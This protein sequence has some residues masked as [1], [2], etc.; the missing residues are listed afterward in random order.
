MTSLLF[1][2][3]LSE[4]VKKKNE[5]KLLRM[6]DETQ[7]YYYLN[8]LFSNQLMIVLIL[9][10]CLSSSDPDLWTCLLILACR[11]TR[12]NV[13]FL[14]LRKVVSMIASSASKF[15]SSCAVIEEYREFSL[16]LHWLSVLVGKSLFGIQAVFSSVQ[17]GFNLYIEVFSEWTITFSI[18]SLLSGSE[19]TENLEWLSEREFSKLDWLS[20]ICWGRR[21]SSS[22]LSSK[23]SLRFPRF[24][25]YIA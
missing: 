16:M 4:L 13:P 25:L 17:K 18:F 20:R 2:L 10:Y 9:L 24:L 22:L 14:E 15:W 23:W 1:M 7:D 3:P 11:R 21:F 12:F 5:S 8:M 19:S 6:C